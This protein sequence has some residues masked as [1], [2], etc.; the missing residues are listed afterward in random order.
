MQIAHF[1]FSSHSRSLRLSEVVCRA[2]LWLSLARMQQV[3]LYNCGRAWEQFH[4]CLCFLS[5]WLPC[6]IS[7]AVF[8]SVLTRRYF[9]EVIK[10]FIPLAW[11]LVVF[12]LSSGHLWLGG[13]NMRKCFVCSCFISLYMG[14]LWFLQVFETSRSLQG[15]FDLLQ[16][17]EISEW[18]EKS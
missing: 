16:C 12:L 11:S 7:S 4:S 8:C 3:S 2:G 15:A 10:A 14:A 18:R 5:Y 13:P 17:L 1:L 6:T 9:Q